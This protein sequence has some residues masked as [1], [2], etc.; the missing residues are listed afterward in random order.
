LHRSARSITHRRNSA[1]SG[2]CTR[3][4]GPPVPRVAAMDE[5]WPIDI[6]GLTIHLHDIRAT[7]VGLLGV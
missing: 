1:L 2:M 4:P 7:R 5:I 6:A 3:H